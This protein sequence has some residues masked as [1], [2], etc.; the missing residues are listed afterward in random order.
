MK[1]LLLNIKSKGHLIGIVAVFIIIVLSFSPSSDAYYGFYGTGLYGGIGLNST[2]GSL[3]GGLYGLSSLYSGLGLYGMGSLYSGLGLYG[4]GGLYNSLY[5]PLSFMGGL[6]GLGGLGMYGLYGGLGGLNGILGT[7][8]LMY[9]LGLT[10]A[11]PL[12]QVTQAVS[13]LTQLT[14]P[15]VTAEQAGTWTGTWISLIKLQAGIIN[16]TLVEDA[17]GTTLTG[18]VNLLLNKITNSIPANVSGL[19]AGGSTFTLTGD[20]DAFIS[21]TLLLV[22]T[23]TPY[24]IQLNCTLTSPT[25]MTG[26]YTIQDLIKLDIDYGNFDLTLS[27]PVI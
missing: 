26:T 14:S 4:L 24:T 13:P 25:T 2:L 16:L 23:I 18:E 12:T 10:N 9:G 11:N 20:N 5:S 19:Y 17:L 22:T 7:I 3:Y 6:Y 27:T 8:G 1:R 15:F 21:T